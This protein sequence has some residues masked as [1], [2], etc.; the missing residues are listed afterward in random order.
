MEGFQELRNHLSGLPITPHEC[1]LRDL[2]Y[3]ATIHVDVE[4][5]RDNQRIKKEKVPIGRYTLNF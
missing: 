3:A 2:T 1:R 5:I 4:Y